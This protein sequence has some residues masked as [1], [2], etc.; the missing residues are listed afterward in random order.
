MKILVFSL[1]ILSFASCT[2]DKDFEYNSGKDLLVVNC[3]LSPENAISMSI[4]KA[5]QFPNTTDTFSIVRNAHITL[6]ENDNEIGYLTYNETTKTYELNYNPKVASQ[7]A[8]KIEVPGYD[9]LTASTYIPDD[10][11][12]ETC[13]YFANYTTAKIYLS[14]LANMESYW[15][16]FVSKIWYDFFSD[17]SYFREQEIRAPQSEDRIFDDF[18]ILDRSSG[19]IY[20]QY[21]RIPNNQVKKLISR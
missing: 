18:N 3:I 15:I 6:I 1:F 12:V 20:S 5:G 7:Y 10:F 8:V 19:N 11:E 14:N 13:Y 16:H 2:L 4:L 9:N 21:L 17:S